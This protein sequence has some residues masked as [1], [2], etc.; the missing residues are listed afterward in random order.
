MEIGSFLI[1]DIGFLRLVSYF[2]YSASYKLIG[3]IELDLFF[4]TKCLQFLLF[5]PDASRVGLPRFPHREFEP[6]GS[7]L[8]Q[9][10]EKLLLMI[11]RRSCSRTAAVLKDQ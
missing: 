6:L 11:P 5:P 9:K 2:C 7:N 1:A 4:K 3:F 10:C 8:T